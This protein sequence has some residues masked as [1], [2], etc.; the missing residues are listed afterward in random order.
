MD[1]KFLFYSRLAETRNPFIAVYLKHTAI[2]IM[3]NT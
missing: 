1:I 2:R 3:N